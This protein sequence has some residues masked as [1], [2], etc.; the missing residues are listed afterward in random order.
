[1]AVFTFHG[2][3][4]FLSHNSKIAHLNAPNGVSQ[5]QAA[6]AEITEEVIDRTY[7][8][9]ARAKR[10]LLW[11]QQ[12]SITSRLLWLGSGRDS[13]FVSDEASLALYQDPRSR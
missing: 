3:K 6:N 10:A 2:I 13:A 8:D 12:C 5:R 1:M 9:L 7:C 4:P 11:F